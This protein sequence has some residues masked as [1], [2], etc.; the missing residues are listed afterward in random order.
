MDLQIS[1]KTGLVTGAS[2]GIGRG[3]ALALGQVGVRL[4]L[5][6]RRRQLLEEVAGQIVG[7][8]GAAPVIID[9]DLMRAEAPGASMMGGT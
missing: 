4:A 5:V 7:R 1:G 8:G 2:S 3:A 6:A 9:C